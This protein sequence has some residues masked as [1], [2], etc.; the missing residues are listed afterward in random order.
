MRLRL[1][2][3]PF[4]VYSFPYLIAHFGFCLRDLHV[5]KGGG[6]DDGTRCSEA[7]TRGAAA[8][9]YHTTRSNSSYYCCCLGN[10]EVTTLSTKKEKKMEAARRKWMPLAVKRR[11]AE[12]D[13]V[14]RGLNH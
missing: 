13:E 7:A 2:L 11:G 10:C 3:S 9:L 1:R 4:P 14:F 6:I 5:Y 12:I 8:V